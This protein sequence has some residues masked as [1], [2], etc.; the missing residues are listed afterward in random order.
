MQLGTGNG[1]RAQDVVSV[2]EPNTTYKLAGWGIVTDTTGNPRVTIWG[3]GM[4][5]RIHFTSTSWSYQ[6][7]TFTTP[8][9][10]S[11]AKVDM[12]KNGGGVATFDDLELRKQLPDDPPVADFSGSPTSGDAPLDV[13]FTDLTTNN[14]TSWDWTFGDGGTDTVQN[15]S[16][17]YAA[18]TYTVSLTA[19]NAAGSDSETKIDYISVTQPPAPVADFSGSPTSGPAPLTVSFTD[20]STNSPTAWDWTFGDGGTDTAQNPSHEYTTAGDYTVSLTATNAGGQ[21]T[22]TKTNYI[23]AVEGGGTNYYV[24]SAGG[25]DNNPG[26]S[27][28]QAWQSLNKVNTITFSPG[29][30]ILLKANSVWNGQ[31][32]YPKG[33]GTNANPIVVD[34][35]DT[36][37]KPLINGQGAY[38]EAVLLYNQEYWELNNLDIT[39]YDSSGPGVRQGVRVVAVDANTVLN[40]IHLKNLD[41]HDVNGSF[42]DGRDKGKT[43][44]GILIDTQGPSRCRFN[45]VLIEGCYIYACDRGAIKTWADW[46]R[47]LFQTWEPLTNLVI[48]NTVVDDIGGDGIV[49]SYADS[50]LFEYN[51][52]SNCQA[53]APDNYYHV[54]IWTWDCSNTLFQYNEAYLTKR[55][56]G[57]GDGQGFDIDAWNN[58][59]VLQYNYSHDNEGGFLFICACGDED[60]TWN[61]GHT[62][63]YN[64]SENDGANLAVFEIRNDVTNTVFYNNT[65]YIG[66]GSHYIIDYNGSDRPINNYWY[67]NIFYNLGSGG[68]DVGGTNIVFDYNVFYGNHPASEPSDAHKLTS[69]PKL[70]NPG[71]G[72]IGMDTVDG[73]KLQSDSP[74]RD[75][76]MTIADN[77]GKDYFGNPVPSG[78]GTD[79]GAHEYQAGPQPPVANFSGNP[80]SGPPTLSVAFT[81]LSANDPT[82]WDWTFGDGGTSTAQSPSHDYTAEG[83][84]TVSLTA[85]NS[86][87][88][89]TETKPDYINVAYVNCHVG[90]IVLVDAG[91]PKYRANATITVHDQDCQPLSGV[92]VDITWSGAA[93]GTDSGGTDGNGQITF[94]SGRN[95]SGGTFTCCVDDLTKSGYPYQSGQN[96]ETCDSIDLPDQS[97]Q[98]PVADFWGSPTSGDAPLDVSFTDTSTNNP[99]SWDWTFGDGGTDTAQNPSHSY[100]AGTYTVSLTAANAEGQDS[101]TKTDYITANDPQPDPPVADFSGSPTS[102]AAPLNVDFTDLSTNAPTAWDWT[103]GD[104]GTD[105]VQH[106][107]HSYAEGTYTVSLTAT[108]A[109]GQDTETKT[110]Y[111]TATGG[112]G[113]DYF[114]STY[115]IEYGVHISG[116]LSDLVSS[117]DSYL[118]VESVKEGGN[119]RTYVIYTFDT[120]LSSLSSLTITIEAHPTIAPQRERIYMWTG[121]GW[122]STV[123]D[124]WRNTT[125]DETLV[126][127]IPDPADYIDPATGEVKIRVRTGDSTKDTWT[128]YIDLVK[129]TAQP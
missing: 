39:N 107:S 36:G 105:T 95:R 69:D 8:S 27:P 80:T 99:T 49:G 7:T 42:T 66:G 90:S 125:S 55:P 28:E 94:T 76:G 78:S 112:G 44:A 41:I 77:G 9:S 26:T 2:L 96:H 58:D 59:F 50:P 71:S 11:D 6:E 114:P 45:D 34:M 122:S 82:S 53:R 10:L 21:D 15:P 18:G 33:S 124:H 47:C 103:F 56:A 89:D 116:G 29:D 110:D 37:A 87:G 31:Q 93:P 23:S 70:V 65:I 74:C 35:Y 83:S 61:D 127:N 13:S 102:G 63:R 111:I 38:Q 72:G 85:T 40:H 20:L 101:E 92:T 118:A 25:N 64:I 30:Q 14:P 91:P 3:S 129:I 109:H 81:D 19:A 17:T 75:S 73:Y 24:D 117:N 119:Q 51:T 46:G 104:G 52:A 88:Q 22:E 86:L 79:R 68:Y 126:S 108:N 48:R 100:A 67:N 43:N 121:G 123:S 120:G 5:Y 98:P 113:G 4:D 97:P 32:L 1:E 54:A 57:R 16:H 128:N 84:Y 115:E 62:I 60:H 106:P 12:A